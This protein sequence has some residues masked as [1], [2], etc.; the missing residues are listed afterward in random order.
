M[1]LMVLSVVWLFSYFVRY[2]LFCLFYIIALTSLRFSSYH[3]FVISLPVWVVKGNFQ[4][5]YLIFVLL[6]VETAFRMNLKVP[7]KFGYHLYFVTIIRD[8]ECVKRAVF[9]RIF[10]LSNSKALL[11]ALTGFSLYLIAI[12]S[13]QPLTI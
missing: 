5:C 9:F 6:C 1:S 2:V 13:K 10:R 12:K 4:F 7:L 8:I 3:Y 11:F